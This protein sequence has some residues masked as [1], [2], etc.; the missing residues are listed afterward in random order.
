[1]TCRVKQLEQVINNL[2]HSPIS[3]IDVKERVKDFGIDA[4]I[5]E[6]KSEEWFKENKNKRVP[7]WLMG[8]F[9]GII[10]SNSLHAMNT[11]INISESFLRGEYFND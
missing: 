2:K 9:L 10:E 7:E 1:M 6:G 4:N 11:A 5:H 8:Q 3:A